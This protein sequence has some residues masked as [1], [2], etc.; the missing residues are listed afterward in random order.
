MMIT[1]R[2]AARTTVGAKANH[3]VMST[4]ALRAAA[5]SPPQTPVPA[6]R[7][8]SRSAP[9]QVAIARPT[10]SQPSAYALT[11]WRSGSVE[12]AMRL[13]PMYI[14]RKRPAECT[15]ASATQKSASRTAS[16]TSKSASPGAPGAPGRSPRTCGMGAPGGC[17]GRRAPPPP[18][19]AVSREGPPSAACRNPTRLTRKIK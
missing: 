6:Q 9:P 8:A 10:S 11:S 4:S 13:R 2:A 3:S 15:S 17:S 7:R 16:W 12:R 19:A 18:P 14:G 5:S 1:T